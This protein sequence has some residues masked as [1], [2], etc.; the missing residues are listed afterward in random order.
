M[1]CVSALTEW[2]HSR[3][4]AITPRVLEDYQDVICDTTSDLQEHLERLEQKVQ[5]LDA[6]SAEDAVQCGTEWQALLEEKQSTQQGLKLCAQLSAQID[7]LGPTLR[8]NPQFMNHPSARKYIRAGL[9]STTGSIQD[10]VSRL[11]KHEENLD[12]QLETVK[13]ALPHSES[14]TT[15][16][17]Q[18]Q[19]TKESIRQCIDIVSAANQDLTG[20]RRNVFEDITMA[21]DTYDFSVSTIGDLVTARRINLQGRARHIGGQI[22]D[23]SYQRTID[24]LTQ[25]H[26][27][28]EGPWPATHDLK[29]AQP[30][31]KVE[32]GSSSTIQFS[33]RY[34]RGFRLPSYGEMVSQAHDINV[35]RGPPQTQ[36]MPRTR[37]RMENNDI[38]FNS[39][40][41]TPGED[42]DVRC[43]R[44]DN[45]S[46]LGFTGDSMTM[47]LPE[48]L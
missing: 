23:E 1:P 8:E 16:L 14:N 13:A 37:N 44:L 12:R 10:L 46:L 17:A 38:L 41:V 26:L 28:S 42:T 47:F 27:A 22:S 19:E 5:S 20:E 9:V 24:A 21:D 35:E 4:A 3:V 11:R 39:V 25:H 32:D 31:L 45:K 40:E 36:L 6:N 29:Q 2:P 48:D 7:Q 43:P 33:D 30:T 15:Q 34:G 18:L